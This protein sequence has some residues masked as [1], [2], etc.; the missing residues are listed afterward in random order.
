MR[1]ASSWLKVAGGLFVLLVL[2]TT[3]L[4]AQTSQ[5]LALAT[6]APDFSRKLPP[7]H[8]PFKL[9]DLRGKKVVLVFYRGLF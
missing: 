6:M 7:P 5:G 4:Q 2:F 3:S 9:S 1:T 8:K